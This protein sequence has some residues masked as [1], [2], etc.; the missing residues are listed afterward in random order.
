MKE[1]E[2]RKKRKEKEREWRKEL[3]KVYCNWRNKKR[4]KERKIGKEIE[5]KG[6]RGWERDALEGERFHLKDTVLH[7]CTFLPFPFH[8]FLWHSLAWFFLYR[9]AD[10]IHDNQFDHYTT[11]H[12][13]ALVNKSFKSLSILRYTDFT[14]V[15]NCSEIFIIMKAVTQEKEKVWSARLLKTKLI[16]SNTI[17]C[18]DADSEEEKR[19]HCF[20]I[21]IFYYSI[22]IIIILYVIL[23]FVILWIKQV[24]HSC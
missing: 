16:R 22:I 17:H 10:I 14:W 6:K 2:E 18:R 4:K 19:L 23:L 13:A 11:L 3:Q 21:Q 15:F 8:I 24:L 1:K 9:T 7:A 5:R 20:F 12:Y